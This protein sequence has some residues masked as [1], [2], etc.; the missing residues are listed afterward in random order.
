MKI[1][2]IGVYGYSEEDFFEAL[3]DAH[4]D[5][6][7]DIRQRRGVRG[8]TNAFANSQRLQQRLAELD[9][10]YLHRKDLAPPKEI[11]QKQYE[12]DKAEKVL[13]R[14][15]TM[16][17]QAFIDAYRD[18]VL[19]NF[20]PQTLLDEIRPEAQTIALF[21]VERDAAACHRS[22]VAEKLQQELGFSLN[23]LE[24]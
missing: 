12:I 22:L 8:A 1:V 7:C 9:I 6:F 23:H 16:L 14:Q 21:C 5:T 13:K 4:V 17:S 20:D 24:P 10:Q 19:D 15:R 2:T 3:K 18:Q 11:R